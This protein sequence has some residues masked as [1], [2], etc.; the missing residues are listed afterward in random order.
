M[1]SAFSPQQENAFA[2]LRQFARKRAFAERCEMCSREL[3]A[4]HEHLVEPAS[5]KLVCAC[6]ACAILF[7]GQSGAK[8]KRVPREVIFLQDFQITDGQW[9]GLMVPI[10]M[11]FFF[12]STPHGKVIALYPSPAGPTESLL[13]LDAWTEIAQSNPALSGMQA[14]V[15][16]LLVNRVGHGRGASAEYYLVPIDECYKLVG[17]IRSYWRGLSGGTEVWREIGAFFAAL[18]KRAGVGQGAHA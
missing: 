17:L 18:K 5:R 16:A 1:P 12:H 3:A 10:E 6:S 11:A 4:D 13:T 14:D 7:E 9:D 2:A 15:T 8:Y